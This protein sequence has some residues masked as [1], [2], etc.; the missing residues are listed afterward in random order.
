MIAFHITLLWVLAVFE[1]LLMLYILRRYQRTGSIYALCGLLFGFVVI[2]VFVGIQLLTS[3][4][5][6]RLLFGKLAYYGGC[7][8]FVS[9]LMLAIEYPIPSAVTSK[10]KTLLTVAPLAFFLPY[11]LF[12][13]DFLR[14]IDL[15][16]AALHVVPGTTFWLFTFFVVM[17]SITASVLLLRKRR[18]VFG[19]QKTQVTLYMTL[20]MLT[21]AAVL[22]D[23]FFLPL[24]GIRTN[25]VLS[26][27]LNAIPVT[28]IAFIV[29]R[30]PR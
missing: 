12:A 15:S 24:N 1:L 6:S 5:T 22:L 10:W 9:N 16:G 7:I 4:D 21:A 28:L 25:G 3:D 19:T 23:T 11:I 30:K 27:Q 29:L 2:A 13:P 8:S 18:R 17:Y 20:F 14:R 26:A